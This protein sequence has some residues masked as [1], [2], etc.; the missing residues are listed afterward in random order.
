MCSMSHHFAMFPLCP[1]TT[2]F[3]SLLPS[4]FYT[5][6]RYGALAIT[7]NVS[8]SVFGGTT[9]LVVSWTGDRLVPAYYLVAVSVIGRS[10]EHTSEL[11]S[12]ENLVCRLLLEIKQK[13]TQ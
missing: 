7:Y 2:L 13:N 10:E 6:V 11:Q 3:R 5:E 1:Y 4:L 12:R 8:A 9:P